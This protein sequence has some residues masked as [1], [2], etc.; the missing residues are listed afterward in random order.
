MNSLILDSKNKYQASLTQSSIYFSYMDDKEKLNCNIYRKFI[1]KNNVNVLKLRKGFE[2]IFKKYDI[3]R[4]K[5]IVRKINNESKLFVII[6]NESSI[7]FENYSYENMNSFIRPY[8][9]SEAPLIRVGFI[10]NEILLID[11]HRIIVD[12]ISIELLIHELIAYYEDEFLTPSLIQFSEYIINNSETFNKK[13]FS[14]E[15]K[16]IVD[17]FDCE[18]NVLTF[19]EK[20]KYGINKSNISLLTK[21]TLSIDGEDYK[22][23]ND[24]I[25]FNNLN[26]KLFFISIY[27]FVLFKYSNQEFIYTSFI[28]NG[29]DRHLNKALGMFTKIQPIIVKYNNNK[30]LFSDIVKE[31]YNHFQFYENN[32][33]SY[34]ELL[35]SLLNLLPV[36]NCFIFEVDNSL[37]NKN[38]KIFENQDNK[39]DEDN[40]NL[41]L[42]KLYQF[43]LIFKVRD[44]QDQYLITID[45]CQ[46]MYDDYLIQNILNSCLEVIKNK[47]LLYQNIHEIEFIDPQEKNR[48]IEHFNSDKCEFIN[49][50][51]HVYFQKIVKEVPNQCAIIFENNKISY[52]KLDE[53]IMKAGGAF[54]FIDPSYPIDRITYMVNEVKAKIIL[55]CINGDD[56]D[57]GS[58][59]LLKN[60][61][62]IYEYNLK[63]HDYHQNITEI[64]N[65]NKYTDISCVF[66]TSGT[67]GQP[68]GILITHYNFI[69]F[70]VY[71][72]KRIEFSNILAFTPFSFN[73]SIIEIF[74]PLITRK[75]VSLCNNNEFNNPELLDNIIKK[76]SLE[77]FALPPTRIKYYITNE[78][79]RNAIYN[80]KNIGF[81]GEGV[82]V[83]FLQ[84]IMKYTKAK[85]FCGYGSTETTSMCTMEYINREDIINGKTI[86]IGKTN[87]NYRIYILD[88]HLKPVPVGTEGQIFV[89]GYSLS[90]GY[91]N[92]EQLTK[93]KFI[94][95]P[96]EKN[97]KMYNTGDIGKWTNDGK[98]IYLGR[99]DFQVK[100][101]GQRIELYEI[102]NKIKEIEGISYTTV[103]DKIKNDNGE[104]YLIGYYISLKNI[105]KKS[106]RDYLKNKLPLYMIP[107]YF[108]KI[109]KIPVNAYGKLNR[110][111]LPEPDINDLL[112]ENYE[113]PETLIEKKLCDIFCKIFNV[114]KNRIGKN[115]DFFELGG[116]SLLTV[117]VLSIIEEEFNIKLNIKDILKY[118]IIQEL[119][120]FIEEVLYN[121]DN[122][123]EA[124]KL[125]K[126]EKRDEKEFPITSQQLGIYIDSIKNPNSIIY[127]NPIAFRLHKNVDISKIKEGFNN[128]FNKQEILKSKYYEKEINDNIEIYGIIDEECILIFE[129]YTY[130]N[131]QSFIR[132]FVL[133]KAPLIRVGFIKDEVLLVDMHHIISDGTTMVLLKNELNNYYR[134]G[135]VKELEIQFKDYSIYLNEQKNS[136]YY[137]KQMEYYRKMFNCDYE[138]LNISKKNDI[139]NNGKENIENIK[140]IEEERKCIC[141]NIINKEL[142]ENI[143]KFTKNNK[144]SKTSF[145][146]SI[147]SNVLSKYS[148]QNEIYTSI[149][150]TNRNNRYVNDMVGMFVTTLPLLLKNNN[151]ETSFLQ[152]I[153]NNMNML[154]D[155]YQHSDISF[156][157]LLNTLKL[158]KVNNSFIYQPKTIFN[159]DSDDELFESYKYLSSN[160]EVN[161][162]ILRNNDTKFDITLFI[163]E[164][165]D[166]YYISLEFNSELYE[167]HLMDQI[168]NSYIAVIKNIYQ[169]QQNIN[170][171]EYITDNDK[172]IILKKFNFDINV[173]G[174]DKFYH[175]EFSKM[176]NQY[177][178][179]CAV[180]YN[181]LRTTYRELNEISNSLGHY[182]RENGIGRNDIIPIISDRSPYYII[183]MISI[184]KAGGAF[185]PIDPKLPIELYD[186]QK[187]NYELNIESIDNINKPD[188]ICYVLFTSGTTGKPKG[189]LITHFNIY[190]NLRSYDF[191]GNCDDHLCLYNLIKHENINN[192]LGITNFSFDIANNE[193]TFSL[194]HGYTTVLVDEKISEDIQSLTIFS[195][196]EL[197][198]N[199]CIEIHQYSN[200]K[201]ING[202]GPTECYFCSYKEI[203]ERVENKITIGKPICNYT[204]YVLDKYL[205]PV[206]IGVE[207]EIFIGGYGVGKGYLNREELTKEKF[208][209]NPFNYND[210]NHNEII[211]RT[212]DLGKWTRN[213]E[214]EYLGRIDFQVK[215]HGQRVELDE[216]ESI[217]NEIKDIKLG[218][219]IDKKREN[220]E[221]YLVCYYQLYENNENE[222]DGAD[223]RKY[224]KNKLPL[225]M[226]PNYYKKINEIN[227]KCKLFNI[228]EN[229]IGK[230]S[231]FFELGGD[232]LNAI[233]LISIF[234][235]ELNLKEI[236]EHSLIVDLSK[237]I[238]EI[239]NSDDHS[240]DVEIIKKRNSKEFPITSQQLGVYIDS[241]KNENNII[242]NMP[243]IFKLSK[244]VNIEKIKEGFNEIFQNQEILKTKYYSKEV[245]GKEEIYGFINDECNLEFEEYTYDNA[246]IFISPFDL[247][248][249]P[250]IRIGFI[251]N[252]YLLIDTHHIISDGATSLI[253]MNELNKYYNEGNIS[254]LEIQYSDY[255]IDMKE[256]QDN[257]IYDKQIEFY[258][259]MFNT[260]YELLN[261]P[262]R[263]ETAFEN[264]DY[265]FDEFD[266]ES[267]SG[268]CISHID[269]L[270]SYS[271]NEYIKSNGISKS[272]FFITVYGYI[273]S[274][275]SGQD[276]IYT[277]IINANRNNHYVENMI[278]MFV[279][280]QS[281]LLNYDNNEVSFNEVTKQNMKCLMEI[282]NNQDISFSELSN[283]LKLKKLNNAFVYQPK[284][285]FTNKSNNSIFSEEI[286]E[287]IY[288]MYENTNELNKDINTKF[289]IT[290]YIVEKD[291]EYLININYNKKIYE[292]STMEN[293]MNS[294]IETIKHINEFNQ[295][296][297]T[298]EYIMKEEKERILYEFNSNEINYEKNQLF[299]EEFKKIAQL[300]PN[301]CA[302]VCNDKEITYLELDEMYI[303]IRSSLDPDFPK[304]RIEYM[305]NEVKAKLIL[306]YITNSENENK[307]SF[308]DIIIYSIDN[309]DYTNN[310][311]MINN[312]NKSEDLCYVLFTSGTTGKP[313]GTL[314]SHN[315]LINY[316][317]Y[318][319]TING[320]EDIYGNDL[321]NILAICKF[322]HD[323]SIGE[324][325]YS[326]VKGYKIILA[327]DNEY[328]N[329]ELFSSLILKHDV[330][331]I[332]T[333]PSRFD[334]YLYNER[335]VK[336]IKKVKWVLLGGEKLE[337][338]TIEKI[339]ENSE[340][341]ILSVYGPTETSVVSNIKILDYNVK[342]IKTITIGK[343]LCNFKIYILD[344][345][346]KPVPI[347]VSGEIFI[348]GEGVGKGYLNRDDLNKE[349]FIDCPYYTNPKNDKL[350]KMYKTGDLGKWTED[351]EIICLGRVDFQVKINGQ[352]I[353]L[354]EI[355]KVINEIDGIKQNVVIDK[356]ND[357][358]NK[359][360]ICYYVGKENMK[361]RKIQES[362]KIKLPQYMIPNYFKRIDK[363]ELTNNGKLNRKALPETDI[364]DMIK[365][366][367]VAP[368]TETEKLICHIYSKLLNIDENEIGKNNDFF[369]L[370]GDSL[371]AIRLISM[372]EKELNIKLNIKEIYEHSLIIDLSKYIEEILNNNDK[373]KDVE[374]I[375]KHN[376]KEFPI[377]SQQL[378]VYIDS[379]KNENTIIYN[380][381]FSYKLNT[382]INIEKIKEG[383]N[384]IFQNQEIFK[385]KYYSKEVNGKEEIYGF[386]D[387][388][389][390]LEFEEYTYDNVSSFIRPFDLSKAPLIPIGFIG[391]EYLL[392]DIHH[393]IANGSAILIIMNELNKYYNE[394]NISE[395]E[396]QY[397]DYAIDMKEK[398]D[399]GFY[400][401]QIEFYKN[402][403]NTEY[404]LAKLPEK[405]KDNKLE[406]ANNFNMNNLCSRIIDKSTSDMINEFIKKNGITKTLFFLTIYGFVLSK[407]SGEDIIY[408]SVINANRSNHYIE[409]MVDT[410][411]EN[412][413]TLIEIFNNQNI[414]LA[415]LNKILKL[416]KINNLF[417]FQPNVSINGNKLNENEI[418]DNEE[419]ED[420]L[421]MINENN[422]NINKS[423]FDIEFSIIEKE[424]EYLILIQYDNSLYD[425]EIIGNLTDSYVEVIKNI[426][427]FENQN[428]D[429]EYIPLNEK[430]MIIEKFNSDINIE[431]CDKFY[432]E[433]FSKIAKQYPDKCAVV[434]NDLRITYRELNEMSNS[435]GHYIRENGSG[436][437]DIIPIISDRSP[438]YI[439]SMIS[440]SK[441]GGAFLP[442]DP[443][444]P[445]ERIQLI[446]E[447]IKPKMILYSNTQDII[448][449]LLHLNEDYRVYDVQKHHYEL[450][451]N[452]IEIINK[453]DDLCYVLFTSGTTGKP[454]GTLITHFN[455]YNYIRSSQGNYDNYSIYNLF[456]KCNKI[457]NILGI[458]NFS[459][460]PSHIETINSLIHGLNIILADE[461][462]RN[463]VLLLSEYI[464][465][466]NVELIKTTPTVLKLFMDNKE[467]RECIGKVKAI[468]LGG[469]VLSMDLCKYVHQYS[470]CNIYNEYGPTECTIACSCKLIDERVDNQI[471]IGKP[472]CNCKV[473]IL[474]KYLKP[475]P[476]GV[477][478][479]IFIGGY[480]VGKE[481][482]NREELTKEKFINNPFNYE[483]DSHNEIIYRTGDLGKW[484]R[485]G[486][487][488]YLGRI[489]F[490]IKIH[491]QRVELDEIES[492]IQEIKDIKQC[493]VIDKKKE[494]EEK[495]LYELVNIPKNEVDSERDIKG[496]DIENS[497]INNITR[498]IDSST[499]KLINNYVRNHGFSKALFFFI[500][501]GYILSKYGGQDTIYSSIMNA[502][503]ENHYKENMIGMFVSTIPVLL[504]YNNE[505]E[506][507][508]L[509]DFIKVNNNILFE[510]QNNK[511]VSFS[512][513]MNSIKLKKINNSFIFQPKIDSTNSE[514]SSIFNVKDQKDDIDI[515]KSNNTNE[516]IN[517]NNSKFDITFFVIEDNEKYI[518]SIEYNSNIYDNNTI[519]NII[520]SYIE[521]FNHI[522]KYDNKIKEIEYIPDNHKEIILNKFNS[523]I[524]KNDYEKLYH[525]E[526]SKIAKFYP[527][528][529][530]IIYNELKL[531]YKELDEMTNSLG[532]YLRKIGITRND[533]IPIISDRSPYYV[534]GVT[535]ISKAGG[536]FLP[537][538]KKLPIELYNLKK[539]N[540]GLNND[541]INNINEPDDIC[542]VLFTSG[543]TGKPKGAL[544]SHFNIYNNLR[545]FD[546]N[547][548]DDHLS[549][550]NLIK[551]ENI[552]NILGITNFSFDISHNE[553]TFSL[554]H[555]LTITLVDDST[556]ENTEL[557]I[558]M[559]LKNN[560]EFINTTPTRF[561]L[562]MENEKFRKILKFIKAIVFIGEELPLDLCKNIHQ[563]SN[564]TII[565]GYGPTECTVTCTYKEINIENC[566]KITI[567]KP[568][569]NYKIYILDKFLKPVPIG[570]EGEIFIGGYGVGIGYL[571]REELTKEKFINNPF[572]Y[573]NDNHNEIIYRT[574]DLGKWTRNGEIEYLGRIDFQVKIHGQRI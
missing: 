419:Y 390:N 261:I 308:N 451:I 486:E 225:Y 11:A 440:I 142:S 293:I 232:S 450:N 158:K 404:E 214:I 24:Y 313:K 64:A 544:I 38:C 545:F 217:V 467:F 433:E 134:N 98:I 27:C 256:K 469:E 573:N 364:Q 425:N 499:S 185:L 494:N 412:M 170:S 320:K 472:L 558:N 23:I 264:E 174:C 303:K 555:G 495:F 529:I 518:V 535:A 381:P 236:Y 570:V 127:N 362:L 571:N 129:S 5:F 63:E 133:S 418:F 155:I 71:S 137:L 388:E 265:T 399:N 563:Y 546:S 148:G 551:R 146:L 95:C 421:T 327:N 114:D 229:E 449:E 94:D 485:N 500:I 251:G 178:D 26:P 173:E 468:V 276:K 426:N 206:P 443:K 213:G 334:S 35:D 339:R 240:K 350:C 525:E 15:Y 12:D 231:D 167:F 504:K 143:E 19:S 75:I 564:C 85:L 483:N 176:A 92:M 62:N 246:S 395:L 40:F 58:K 177:P 93:E 462:I 162:S 43:S 393:V 39:E 166:D 275:Y 224:L 574:G 96:F 66:F 87:F 509:L 99:E 47:D 403:F 550:C 432:H 477:E 296:V 31:I 349:K 86:T 252:D 168:L 372:I 445:I 28:N 61:N 465:D 298:I 527:E 100:I 453:P 302:I 457:N 8:N 50:P 188:D 519:N 208:I 20:D 239:L 140:N 321:D 363:F 314:I 384:E 325:N 398:Q 128:I 266:N 41:F 216:I 436:R 292:Q 304:E 14:N 402:M 520:S 230:T 342:D 351:G 45:Y 354:E 258:R 347:G 277:S 394:G 18:Y 305:V 330:Q 60:E 200:C 90:I 221:K 377:T 21:K 111:L 513:L 260:E 430:Q 569:C 338:R 235:K 522:E 428:I 466:N 67:T 226:I 335:F 423:K 181:D 209:N 442:I 17:L 189:A 452:S 420:V 458:T 361:T 435:L 238:E 336:S 124:F 36:N 247:S 159:I 107:K 476:I 503:R 207:G 241:I 198:F 74:L 561:K 172:E 568:Q 69:N 549:L 97:T 263:I 169:Y 379:I 183:S 54:V 319:Q 343:P 386:I 560:V 501:Y 287:E 408:T 222:I 490:Q 484:T 294:Y 373:S 392:I 542:Y 193:I 196:E 202:Y 160:F 391:N 144:I 385:T 427:K 123:N 184:S 1:F 289:D 121:S 515:F 237:Y 411:K 76:Y 502:N 284:G 348:A 270:T 125:E 512:E 439:I 552:N 257:G 104:K 510:I 157:E 437:N 471:N 493:V 396:I 295:N 161:T 153:K 353:E 554:I 73:I 243:S 138:L 84:N 306:K 487:I 278:G 147:Y 366:E 400:D 82:T 187:H 55:K 322:S 7:N 126:I 244:N 424:N 180:V 478:G 367:Y 274:K 328:N 136:D 22:I 491:G 357:N 288:L 318:S 410:I 118:S 83:D 464:L 309:H 108:V 407:Y 448:A 248:K 79:F 559:I 113:A 255:A 517:D 51:Y 530:A 283:T 88:K 352:R 197:P 567:G 151:D 204:L 52:K 299:H 53:M 438:Y 81:G 233:R 279:S 374:I 441:A 431:G 259:K 531:S 227:D 387:D 516:E 537:I 145:F 210:D 444:L 120:Q 565:N 459:F 539:H 89:G 190:N 479:E 103:I 149:M 3:L 496:L 253:I 497:N 333:V 434:Y 532:Y 59:L 234:E 301:K 116:D 30:C 316:C 547:N 119:G 368:E 312:V 548:Y 117:K 194:I 10:K 201:I 332:F 553:I 70:C 460:D 269:G 130:E 203:N 315:N 223:I 102:E 110:K 33:I 473:Y 175:E 112:M 46:E 32:D 326:L 538:D 317:L 543:T 29:K 212:G 536:A 456:I 360:L 109:D 163:Y 211:Y 461:N 282:Y 300:Y 370:G 507:N 355:E 182:I 4:T 378:G 429:I 446:L 341:N 380:M 514:N 9:L 463:N 65:I 291:E 534:I 199:L 331:Y 191:N 346:L 482:L 492:I 528:R 37:K 42:N 371:N 523:D 572:N 132:P 566:N 80:V 44:C 91:L 285:I 150:I 562:F 122:K 245:N 262:K 77:V 375:K 152:N 323:I 171:I 280:T 556:S 135:E 131:A 526:F 470:N 488:E 105:S 195:G 2:E 454:K 218:V 242:Y 72:L 78:N 474:D 480:G 481:Y 508:T 156:S 340:C 25:K 165:N 154:M 369:E 365:E 324:I 57:N 186:V 286:N 205:K 16:Y 249:A 337:K 6:D 141:S 192:I 311:H 359:Y 254:E 413:N 219:V 382:N 489:D 164:N 228:N 415:E 345:Y 389:C 271:V 540:Y 139:V 220:G 376:C 344:K 475:V 521:I 397:S 356:I 48:I 405:E 414:S 541:S 101:H 179:K 297:N 524:N 417:V 56:D 401:K 498:I 49:V 383:F 273:L 215:I 68:K 250:L 34:S 310:K 416:K 557:L 505:N 281:V 268:N 115:S 267:N 506:E 422:N 272:A 406:N 455:L 307:I 533:I 447:E 511:D 358:G 409:N 106:I 329:P 290:F 13:I